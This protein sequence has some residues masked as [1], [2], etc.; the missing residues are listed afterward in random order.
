MYRLFLLLLSNQ[1]NTATIYIV[2]IMYDNQSRDDLKHV[3]DVPRSYAF[4]IGD[5]HFC[6]RWYL[7]GFPRNRR[8]STLSGDCSAKCWFQYSEQA[9]SN[10]PPPQGGA[11]AISILQ[12]NK[13]RQRKAFCLR[14]RSWFASVLRFEWRKSDPRF[15][16]L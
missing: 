7:L 13:L 6:R 16:P 15:K 11:W 10:P 8:L 3:E 5:L 2:F 14:S 1:H 12:M 9:L 4:C